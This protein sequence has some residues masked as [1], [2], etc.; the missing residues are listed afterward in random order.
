VRLINGQVNKTLI[1]ISL[2]SFFLLAFN[3]T[4]KEQTKINRKYEFNIPVQSLS[5]SLNKLSDIAKISFLFPYDLVKNKEGKSVQGK[6]TTQQALTMLLK[7]TNLEGKLSGKRAFLIKPLT[8]NNNLGKQQMNHPKTLLATIF[9]LMFS[10]ASSAEEAAQPKAS[11]KEDQ[12]EVIQVRGI[13]GSMKA[14][15][16]LKRTDGRIMDAIVAEDIG[17]LPDNNIAEA[18]QRISGV[19]INTDFGVGESVSIRGLSENRVE[20]NGRSTVGDSRDGVSLDDFPS[21]FLKSVSVIK[22]PTAD[23][24]EGALGGT[25]SMETV[26]PLELKEMTAAMS[27]DGEYADKTENWAPIFNASIGNSWELGDAGSFGAIFMAS[28]QD[29]EIR[30]DEFYNRVR[31]YDEDAGGAGAQGEGNTAS[32]GYAVR[33]QNTQDQ[34]VEVRE[35]TAFNLSLQWAPASGEGSFYL[36]LSSTERDG[37]QAGNSILDVGGSRVY[38]E[39]TTQDANGQLNNYTLTDA[40]TIPKTWSEFRATKSTSNAFGGDWQLTDTIRIS[41]EISVATSES[42]EPETEL[43]LRPVNHTN[44]NTWAAQ[45]DPAEWA[46]DQNSA[47]DDECRGEFDCRNVVDVAM[48]QTGD[49]IPS[50]VY[51]DPLTV[52]SPEN[53]AIRAFYHNDVRTE[54]EETAIRFDIEIDEPL[55]LEF[56]S[57]LKAGVRT[58]ERDYE[59]HKKTY[60]ADNLYRQ[61]FTDKDTDNE[62]PFAVWMDDFEAAFPGTFSTVDYNKTFNQTGISGQYDLGTYRTYRG[63]LLSDAAGSFARIQQLFAGT[64]FATTGT[65]DDNTV[66]DTNAFRDITEET[67]ALY[68]SA[69]LDFDEIT[70]IVGGRYITTDISSAFYDPAEGLVSDDSDYSDFLPSIN[71]TY[72]L[73]D[74]T[75]VRFAAAKVMRRADFEELSPALDINNGIYSSTSGSTGLNPF[76]ATQFDISVEHYY[77]ESNVASFAI[78]YKDV[79]SFLSSENTCLANSIASTQ[80]VTEWANICQLDSVGVNNDNLVFASEAD[81]PNATD[82]D[83]AGFNAT[84]DLRDA[85][86]TGIN[87]SQRTNGENG[88][89]QGFEIGIQ[90]TLDFLPGLGFSANYT[91]ADSEQPNGNALLDISKSTVNAQIYWENEEFQVRLAYNFRDRFLDTEEETRVANVGALAL[92]DSTNDETSANFD[93]TAGN[94][95]RESR[96]Q[97]DI[98][99]SWDVNEHFTLVTN[100]TNLTGE[101]S[102]YSTELGSLWKYTEADRRLTLGVRAKF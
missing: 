14:A 34:Y 100:M 36:D 96:G 62:A 52:L 23:M 67:T 88:K 50:V 33:E 65:L 21:S 78:F 19:S 89:V 84:Q 102:H 74:E 10:S 3:V 9:T 75:Q 42:S 73:S 93:A 20:L 35:R 13:L 39:N 45:Y 22:S 17:K 83:T 55:G 53:L 18:L 6:Y 24:I 12:I 51:S 76:R 101:P 99:A 70:A 7:N 49:N 26:R 32:G 64:N 8:N 59:Y 66:E 81:F 60:R 44:W 47:F 27:L 48:F 25:V 58:T 77:G 41:G 4:A 97:F 46:G 85:G 87:N 31:I 63:D 30:Q 95:Y 56:I 29:R 98:S 28:Y 1:V 68:V 90:Q 54:N 80:N 15:A 38:N 11:E 57:S 16:I 2:L 5:Q 72:Q 71:V 40:F 69:H 86:L 82:K 37:S 91:Y 92:N 61:A 43:N 79:E 94:N